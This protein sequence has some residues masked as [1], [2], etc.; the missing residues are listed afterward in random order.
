V[1]WLIEKDLSEYYANAAR[2]TE[3]DEKKALAMLS[4]WEKEHE[5]FFKKYRDKLTETYA[6]M[7]WGG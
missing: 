1:A 3:G 5:R 6:N 7:P 4:Q 2:Q